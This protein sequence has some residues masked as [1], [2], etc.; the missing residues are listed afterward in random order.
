MV[1]RVWRV[2]LWFLVRVFSCWLQAREYNITYLEFKSVQHVPR[3]TMRF[4]DKCRI[5]LALGCV[6][7]WP[8]LTA[9]S[10]LIC[11]F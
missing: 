11:L 10:S 2:F 7:F 9:L 3:F 8:N 5:A 6:S 1:R 4:C